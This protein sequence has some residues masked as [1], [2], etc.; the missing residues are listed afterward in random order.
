MLVMLLYPR[1][2]ERMEVLGQYLV[3]VVVVGVCEE[4]SGG[5]VKIER[6]KSWGSGRKIFENKTFCFNLVLL[7]LS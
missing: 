5:E 6:Y 3:V 7:A 4:E 1:A 2:L